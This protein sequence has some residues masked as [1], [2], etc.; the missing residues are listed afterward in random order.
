VNRIFLSRVLSY[1]FL[2]LPFLFCFY[3]PFSLSFRSASLSVPSVFSTI[4]TCPATEPYS[5]EVKKAGAQ[6][7]PNRAFTNEVEAIG[8]HLERK[9]RFPSLSEALVVK[10]KRASRVRYK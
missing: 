3:A 5:I 9:N 2:L 4:A 10:S 7:C 8:V 6:P 1:F